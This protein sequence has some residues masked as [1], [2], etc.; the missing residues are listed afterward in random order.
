M[1]KMLEMCMFLWETNQ[2]KAATCIFAV[3]TIFTVVNTVL[4]VKIFKGTPAQKKADIALAVSWVCYPLY[5]A[6]FIY[7]IHCT[8]AGQCNVLGWFYVFMALCI[9]AVSVFALVELIK[10]MKIVEVGKALGAAV[11]TKYS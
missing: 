6:Y 9:V 2:S 10:L 1:I 5:V 3:L 7:S 8:I 4:Y 11:Q